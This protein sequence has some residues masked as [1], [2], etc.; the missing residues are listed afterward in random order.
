MDVLVKS[1]SP[2]HSGEA[3]LHNLQTTPQ[4]NQDRLIVAE[5]MTKFSQYAYKS[6][7]GVSPKQKYVSDSEN[8]SSSGNGISSGRNSK[9]ITSTTTTDSIAAT[10]T[11]VNNAKIP[12]LPYQQQL[13]SVHSSANASVFPPKLIIV[14]AKINRPLLSLPSKN[15]QRGI[16]IPRS[17]KCEKQQQPKQDKLICGRAPKTSVGNLV[18][19]SS[20]DSVL[21]NSKRSSD[22]EDRMIV[23]PSPHEGKKENENSHDD[24]TLHKTN[25]TDNDDTHENNSPIVRKKSLPV[26]NARILKELSTNNQSLVYLIHPFNDNFLVR[27]INKKDFINSFLKVKQKIIRITGNVFEPQ[28]SDLVTSGSE[29]PIWG[30]I[31]NS[32]IHFFAPKESKNLNNT[33]ILSEQHVAN[34]CSES[35]DSDKVLNSAILSSTISEPSLTEKVASSLPLKKRKVADSV[36][37]DSETQSPVPPTF[38]VTAEDSSRL[39]SISQHAEQCI[40]DRSIFIVSPSDVPKF[41]KTVS[42]VQWEDSTSHHLTKSIQTAL[43]QDEDGDLPLHIAV[44]QKD[45][46]MVSL[47]GMLIQRAGKSVDRFN[48]KNLTPLHLCVKVKFLEGLKKLIQMG[49]DVNTLDGN[50]QSALHIAVSNSDLECFDF[51]LQQ[52]NIHLKDTKMKPNLNSHDYKGVTLLH[53]A[54][55]NNSIELIKRLLQAGAELDSIDFKSGRTPL[56]HAVENKNI[57]IVELLLEKKASVDIPN[58]AGNTAFLAA[59]ARGYHDISK[60]LAENGADTRG[61]MG[62]EELI[63]YPKTSA[64]K[65]Q[66]KNKLVSGKTSPVLQET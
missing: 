15:V 33:N 54:V 21:N 37:T 46:K 56:F 28:I 22:K 30:T 35:N 53:T 50:G 27:S 18:T 8:S 32:S 7:R 24:C 23:D 65:S 6:E 49:A 45:I 10:T 29:F 36:L 61:L 12:S 4:E 55:N 3:V 51:L 38:S 5:V 48:K 60:L 40:K 14:E 11:I 17:L 59:N 2:T 62:P 58:F 20:S 19:Y 1:P 64:V 26:L 13:S 41:M 66:L 43:H 9:L 42:S 44:V 16:G 25:N 39:K 57:K 31:K 63:S 47:Y 34:K 52:C